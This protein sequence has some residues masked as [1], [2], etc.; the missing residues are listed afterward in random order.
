MSDSGLSYCSDR[1]GYETDHKRAR[2]SPEQE[3]LEVDDGSDSEAVESMALG[4]RTCLCSSTI[5]LVL[6]YLT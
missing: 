3:V 5:P 1:A 4:Q 2:L 6:D